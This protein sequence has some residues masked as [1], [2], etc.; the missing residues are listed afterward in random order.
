M[1]GNSA[2]PTNNHLDILNYL[3]NN[4]TTS[5]KKIIIPLSYGGTESYKKV[6]I[7]E[8]VSLFGDRMMPLQSFMPLDKYT[9]IMSNCK[10][11]IFLP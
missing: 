7:D 6:V 10:T 11:A 5:W 2:V 9:R 4:D 1:I 3:R 8:G